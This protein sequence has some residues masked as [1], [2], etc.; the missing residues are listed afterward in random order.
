MIAIS[1]N[2]Y[3][4]LKLKEGFRTQAY[5]DGGGVW[6]IGYGS[7]RWEDGSSI[8]PGQT[9][10]EPRAFNLL[11]TKADGFLSQVAKYI[12]VPL[13]QN[14]VDAVAAFVYNIGVEAFEGSTFLTLLNKND[15]A[16]ALKQMVWQDEKGVYHGW[17][18]VNGHVDNGLINRRHAEQALFNT[19]VTPNLTATAVVDFS[20]V[21]SGV[22]TFNG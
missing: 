4:F 14:Q 19:P 22:T 12:L 2:G 6:T 16:G 7:T 17:I 21:Q 13:N 9:I 1:P 5:P 3:A 10:D 18:H 8:K 15:F 20:N 11:K